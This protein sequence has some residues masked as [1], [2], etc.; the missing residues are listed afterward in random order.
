MNDDWGLGGG[1]F[2]LALPGGDDAAAAYPSLPRSMVDPK[3]AKK[4]K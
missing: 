2:A 1:G 4:R 3:T